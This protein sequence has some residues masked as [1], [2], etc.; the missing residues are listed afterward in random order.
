MKNR[1]FKAVLS[2]VLA[3]L[4]LLGSMS[5]S[6]AANDFEF[7]GKVKYQSPNGVYNATKITHPNKDLGTVDGVV[8]YIGNNQ[9]AAHDQ[10]QGDRAQNYI[11][12][13]IGY[14]D[15]IYGSTNYSSMMQTL[16]FMG[17]VLGHKY[18]TD[19]MNSLLNTMFNG[20]FFIEEPDGGKPSG[21]L[22]K[23]NVKTGEVK[24]IMTNPKGCQLRNAIEYKDKIYFCG[25]V[26]GLPAVVQVDPANNDKAEVIYRGISQADYYA[27][28]LKGISAAV[29]GIC[30]YD[31]KFIVSTITLDGAQILMSDHPWDG[32][33]AFEV[34]ATQEDLYDYPAYRFQDSIYGGSIWEM[35]EFN[36][37]LYV[38]ICTGRPENQPDYNTMQSFAIVC[39]EPGENGEWTWTP[40]IGDKEDGAKY[41][42]GIDP[43]RTRAGAG[44]LNIYNGYLYIGE[45]NDEEIPLERIIFDLDFDFMNANLDQSVNLYRMDANEDIELI[46]GDATEMFPEGGQSGLG[47]GFGRHE[48]QYIW[49]MASYNGKLYVGTFD[50]SSLLQPIGQ[51]VNKDI[52]RMSDEEWKQLFGYIQNFLDATAPEEEEDSEEVAA[53]RDLFDTYTEDQLIEMATGEEE[54]EGETGVSMDVLLDTVAGLIKTAA[55]LSKAER[56][57]DLYVSEDGINFKTITTNG[58]GDPTNHG[59]RTFATTEYGLGIGTANPFWA[60]QIWMMTDDG[61]E[62]EEE[63]KTFYDYISDFMDRVAGFIN[64][65]Q[66]FLDNF[67]SLVELI[68]RLTEY[69][70]TNIL[71]S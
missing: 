7:V 65:L 35:V 62:V 67:D 61:E 36:K 59:L 37:K 71:L 29:R 11:W 58:F 50:T 52:M 18:D 40:V 30:V 70:K 45:Y 9:V 21:V 49:R 20:T 57:F 24:V 25:A 4:M 60:G 16:N 68:P 34:I 44:V 6:L 42:F 13:A 63:G 48:N 17:T 32:Q 46:V 26:D 5:T 56:G 27:A 8:D 66:A 28:Y 3:T 51:F 33:D 64:M 38:S 41:T 55:Y 10:G 69:V 39:G 54:V 12:S 43:E 2:V 23:I 22:F 15:Y 53:M 47:S 19:V 14:G 31:G 1:K